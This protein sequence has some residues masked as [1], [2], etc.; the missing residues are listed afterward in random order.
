MSLPI[1]LQDKYFLQELDRLRV[2]EEYIKITVLNWKEEPLEQVQGKVISGGVNMDGSSSMRR[3]ATLSIYAESKNNNLAN[4]DQLFSINKKCILEKGIVN[5]VPA[6]TF[7]RENDQGKME[8][9]TINYQKMYG[10]IVWFPL[11]LY[12]MFNP[13]ISHDLNGVTISMNLKDKMCLLNGDLGGAIHSSVDF[14][15][16]DQEVDAD[17]T[18]LDS[19]KNLVYNIIKELVNHWGNESLS[20]IIISKV[21]LVIKKVV[22]WTGKDS[23]WILKTAT[24]NVKKIF[25]DY[26]Q[27][28]EQGRIYGLQ[29]QTIMPGQDMGFVYAPFTYP[30]DEFVC[31]TGETVTSVLDK[32]INVLGNY[33]YFYDVEGKFIFREK[34]N[35]LNMTNVAYWSK[36][37]SDK[38]SN[39]PSDIYQADVYRL[40]TSIYDFTY[41]EFVVAY[42]NSLN[43][44]NLKNDFVVWGARKDSSGNKTPCRFHLAIDKKPVLNEHSFVLYKDSFDIVR[45]YGMKKSWLN[46]TDNELEGIELFP[47]ADNE[48]TKGQI[49]GVIRDRQSIDWR[50]QIY[51][52]M[53]EDQII[54]TGTNT[55]LN[56]TYFQYYP[57]LKEEFPKIFN[58]QTQEWEDVVLNSPEQLDYFLDFIDEQSQLG[59]YSVDNIGRRTKI[60]EDSD[61]LN[62]VF[63]PTIP[64][65]V[66]ID[67]SEEGYQQL[68]Q[69]CQNTGQNWTQIDN[70]LDSLLEVSGTLNSC[71]EKIKDLLYEYTHVNNTISIT[72]LPIYY[73]EPNTRITVNDEESGIEGDFIIQSISLPLDISSSM[74]INAYQAEQKI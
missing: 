67:T 18:S 43:F 27:A 33:E 35:Y 31:N 32:I 58:L 74:T 57:E 6:Q 65:V 61:N 36:E 60:V 59:K 15:Y 8:T 38:I 51:Y 37:Q 17:S 21:P 13:S 49:I 7:N 4:I 66:F 22:K 53:L 10:Q 20:N 19:R 34:Q 45:G 41:N 16:V 12:I 56:N 24:D 64:D 46:K 69:K 40:S 5:N 55:E 1:F 23:I 73:L 26:D 50:Q 54:G 72:C 44:N 28:V 25:L 48:E 71:F 63:E 52:Q 9:I 2:K 39:L 70:Y 3:T 68:Q 14:M 47:E 42:N 62:C 29:P 30:E 11:G